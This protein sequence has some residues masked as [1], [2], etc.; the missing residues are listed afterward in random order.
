MDQKRPLIISGPC[1]AE[2]REQVLSTAQAL[3]ATG[4]VDVLRAGIWKPR[5]KPGNFEGYG[6]TALPWLAE[7][8]EIT[9]LQLGV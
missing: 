9:G 3:A 8:R 2:S 5:T 1:S 4:K 7:A 6:V